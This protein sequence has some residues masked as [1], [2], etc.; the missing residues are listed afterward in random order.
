MDITSTKWNRIGRHHHHGIC[1]PLSSI[2]TEKSCGIGEYL[3]LIPLIQW[4]ATTGFDTIQLLPLNDTGDDPSPYMG[5]SSCAL[6]PIHLSLRSLPNHTAVPGFSKK[7]E[8]LASLNKT[9][10]VD[11]TNVLHKKME[12]ISLYLDRFLVEIEEDPEFQAFFEENQFWLTS[13]SIFKALKAVHNGKAWWDWEKSAQYKIIDETPL[14][15]EIL[16]WRVIQYLCF[17]QFK[18]V[19]QA[20]DAHQVLLKGDVPILINK[21]SVDAWW[22]PNLFDLNFSVGS[23]P[24]T[25]NKDG[26]HWNFPTYQWNNHR[27][28]NFRW[29]KDRLRVKEKLYHI[30]RLDHIIGFFRFW[31]I[32]PQKSARDGS[33]VPEHEHEWK[34]LGEEILSEIVSSTSMLPI[35]EE[36]GATEDVMTASI[37]RLGIPVVKV[38]R[39]ERAHNVDQSFINPKL[40]APNTL[41]TLSTHDIPIMREW[42]TEEP[43]ASQ[44][45]AHELGIPWDKKLSSS[46]LFDLLSLCHNSGSLFHINMF[47]ELLT[48]FPDL[49]WNSAARE[50]INI[51]GLILPTNWT[52]RCKKGLEEICAHHEL[53]KALQK[54]SENRSES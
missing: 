35:G 44:R 28:D 6:H 42:W 18:E 52:Y 24:D 4:L 21:D 29:W 49:S 27:K 7:I 13:Y 50:R 30:Y 41:S 22:N 38:M 51:P 1:F 31:V 43:S 53:L 16:R 48:L 39:W 10:R 12:A 9:E 37:Q 33:F 11:Y 34:S 8:E 23:P 20:A 36:L 45:L 2:L 46:T 32:P 54:L 40:Y 14:T 26:Q 17:S 15:N 25:Y 3:D 19:K 5:L 47:N